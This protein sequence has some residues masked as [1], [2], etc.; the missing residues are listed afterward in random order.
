MFPWCVLFSVIMHRF[1]VTPSFCTILFWNSSVLRLWK[2]TLFMGSWQDWLDFSSYPVS[3][4]NCSSE[5]DTRLRAPFFWVMGGQHSDAAWSLKSVCVVRVTPCSLSSQQGH[6]KAS[7]QVPGQ[8]GRDRERWAVLVNR[9]NPSEGQQWTTC[10]AVVP[11]T[12]WTSWQ[13]PA[14]HL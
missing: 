11:V 5:S 4:M 1:T 6:A 12:T 7:S 9:P 10:Q 2:L 3:G 13:I 14:Y 8:G